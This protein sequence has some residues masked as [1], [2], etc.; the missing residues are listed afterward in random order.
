MDL[1]A[2]LHTH[3]LVAIVRGDDPG[4]ALRSV[5]AL[6]EE[7]VPLIEV[8]LSGKGALEVIADAR[9]ALGP[10]A[11]LG[12]GTV[13]TADDA[14][15]AHRAGADFA[16]TPGLG[17]GASTAR[18]L[19]LPVLAGVMTPTDII[20]AQAMGAEAFKIFPAAQAGGPEYVRALR[21]PFPAA[22]FVPVGG[23]DAE[24]AR[25]Y[26]AAGA[27]AV[28]VGSPLLGDA[29]SGGSIADLRARAAVFRA[30]VAS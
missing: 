8:S 15:A 7:G 13:L 18:E 30:A 28:G 25:A 26:L 21:G 23:V 12:A 9:A 6:A 16:V 14:R 2:A 3:R 10:D 19:G 1:L 27:I 24:A 11:P 22:P 5:L 29:P 20:A 17:A 4:A